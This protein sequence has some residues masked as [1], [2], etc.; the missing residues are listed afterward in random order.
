MNGERLPFILLSI[1]WDTVKS[2]GRPRKSQLTQVSSLKKEL[3]VQ[4]KAL[5]AK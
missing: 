3:N 2:I 5:N 4:D 1:E